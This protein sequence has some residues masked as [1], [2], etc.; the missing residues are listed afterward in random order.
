MRI[1]GT[2]PIPQEPCNGRLGR[3]L[4][5]YVDRLNAGEEIDPA[6]ISA[7]HPDIA[8]ELIDHLTRFQALGQFDV[9]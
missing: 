9:S 1:P 4:G 3:L 6:Q 5:E 8:R 2:A 7:E